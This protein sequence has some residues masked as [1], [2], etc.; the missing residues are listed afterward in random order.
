MRYL[1]V[2]KHPKKHFTLALFLISGLSVLL[3]PAYAA[4][5]TLE[6][7]LVVVN[8]DVITREDFNQYKK[9]TLRQLAQSNPQL[10]PEAQ[11]DAQ[12]LDRLINERIQMQLAEQSGLH[13]EEVQLKR[14]LERIAEDSRMNVPQLMIGLERNGISVAR[15]KE[16]IRREILLNRL[17]EREIGSRIT[18]SETDIDRFWDDEKVKHAA[19]QGKSTV[20]QYHARHILIKVNESLTDA[21]AKQKIEDIYRKAVAKPEEFSKLASQYS[22]DGTAQKGGDLGWVNLG[23][24][25]PEFEHAMTQLKPNQLSRPIRTP[26]GYH[27]IQLVEIRQ[28]DVVKN[29]DRTIARNAIRAQK[30]EETFAEWLR[31]IRAKATVEYRAATPPA[32]AGVPAPHQ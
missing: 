9:I 23:D 10:P 17:Q 20:P 29:K 26:F 13:V 18:I 3:S 16:E 31:D 25:V 22:E 28:Y 5:R 19:Q 12:L 7:I 15:F 14:S 24:T 2:L 1:H 4:R 27:L 30:M 11:L 32:T 6:E 8:N 21:D